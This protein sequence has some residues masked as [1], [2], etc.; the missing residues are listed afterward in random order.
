M[1]TVA[2]SDDTSARALSVIRSS[3]ATDWAALPVAETTT[4]ADA[5]AAMRGESQI[6]TDGW[7]VRIGTS[8][9]RRRRTPT[10]A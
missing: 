8:R 2:S 4:D 1:V 7:T 3:G 6:G 5:R 9:D 10:A